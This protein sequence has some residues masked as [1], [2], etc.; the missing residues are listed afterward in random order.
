MK[1]KTLVGSGEKIGWLTFWDEYGNK[2]KM[3]WL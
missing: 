2:V 1:L 3:P